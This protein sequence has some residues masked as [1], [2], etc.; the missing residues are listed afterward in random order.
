[1]ADELFLLI[2]DNINYNYIINIPRRP[3][4]VRKTGVDQAKL[5]AQALS[6]KINIK[7][8]PALKHKE[9]S[10][11]QKFLSAEQRSENAISSYRISRRAESRLAAKSVILIDDVTTTG[12]T[13]S[14]GERL[15]YAAG[16]AG[17]IKITVAKAE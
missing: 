17:V 14:A 8:L 10:R 2:A 9:F 3:S 11:E 12:S 4:A 6:R 13:L 7:Y 15:L 1:M 16:A 5:L